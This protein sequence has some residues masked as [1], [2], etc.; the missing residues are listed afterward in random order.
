MN[1]GKI[2]ISLLIVFAAT[3]L[4]AA[5]DA[6]EPQSKKSDRVIATIVKESAEPVI[7]KRELKF[8]VSEKEEEPL[9]L[10]NMQEGVLDQRYVAT[11]RLVYA[12]KQMPDETQDEFLR[13]TGGMMGPRINVIGLVDNSVLN[14]MARQSDYRDIL[15]IGYGSE[16]KAPRGGVGPRFVPERFEI[17]FDYQQSLLGAYTPFNKIPRGLYDLSKK[18]PEVHRLPEKITDAFTKKNNIFEDKAD[19]ATPTSLQIRLL[20][21]SAEEAKELAQAWLTL[22]DWGLCYPAQKEC[23]D[24][25]NKLKQKLA[26]DSDQLPKEEKDLADSKQEVEKYKDFEDIKPETIL[27]LTT[28]R[29]LLSVDLAGIKARIEAC[30]EMLSQKD[31]SARRSEQIEPALIAAQIELRGLAA[32][33]TEI[34]RIIQG[35]QKRQ[36]LKAHIQSQQSQTIPR[37]NSTIASTKK[38][39]Q[40]IKDY[41]LGYESLPVEDG[42]VTIRRIKWVS[43]A[44]K[45]QSDKP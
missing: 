18:S 5:E 35:A 26:E 14:D 12:K 30:Q 1:I 19:K 45:P 25:K 29:R 24:V 15:M 32:K 13:R 22:Y 38:A 36:E 8:D 44:N 16:R 9:T 43:P 11:F 20:A 17:F 31:I 27:N 41:Q 2:F 6:I 7:P 37:L 42:K 23:L 4:F 34:D 28:Q 10:E 40:D 3:T 39:I 21:S 33:Q